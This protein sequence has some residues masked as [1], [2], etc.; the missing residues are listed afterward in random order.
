MKIISQ[1][2]IG[3]FCLIVLT[4][5]YWATLVSDSNEREEIW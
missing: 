1:W 5:I 4:L 2:V 3:I